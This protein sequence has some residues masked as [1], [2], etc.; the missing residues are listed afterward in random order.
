MKMTR[1]FAYCNRACIISIIRLVVLSRLSR[2]DVTWNF[3]NSA[4]WSVAEPCIGVIS[5]CIPSLRPGFSVLVRGTTKALGS[6]QTGKVGTGESSSGSSGMWTRSTSE[7]DQQ[8][9]FHRLND[10]GYSGGQWGHDVAVRGGQQ[11][12]GRELEDSIGVDETNVPAGGIRVKKEIVV[13]ST[14]WLEYRER[15]F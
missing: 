7:T 13:T 5:A 15:L 12:G 1:S 11:S 8:G 2:A 14:N 10:L 6:S 9:N 4:I 3:V